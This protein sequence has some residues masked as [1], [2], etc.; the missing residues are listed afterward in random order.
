MYDLVIGLRVYPG[1]SKKPVLKGTKLETFEK[2]YRSL[3]KSIGSLSTRI[4]VFSDGCGSDFHQLITRSTPEKYDFEIIQVNCFSGPKSFKKQYDYL[5]SVNAKLVA[6]LEDDYIFDVNALEN[7]FHFAKSMSFKGYYTFFNSSD[8]YQHKLH[9]YKSQIVHFKDTYW[10]SVAS[11]TL[12]FICSPKTLRK[13]KVFFRTYSLGNFDHNIW[14]LQTKLG[15][16]CLLLSIYK[17]FNPNNLKRVAKFT[18]SLVVMFPLV[19]L[20]HEKLW[21]SCPGM[22]THLEKS[23]FSFDFSIDNNS[24]HVTS[25]PDTAK[26]NI[27]N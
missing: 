6:L 18:L 10:R 24:I 8:Y 5:S 22:G 20:R 1:I 13:N 14:L 23:G 25:K 16:N 26:L 7:I 15:W 9:S 27:K 19:L 21:V 3:V 4:V 12:T 2:V 11:T 17:D